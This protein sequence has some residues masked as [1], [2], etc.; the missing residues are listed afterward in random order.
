MASSAANEGHIYS[1]TYSN[2][3]FFSCFSSFSSPSPHCSFGLYGHF[4]TDWLPVCYR[5]RSTNTSWELR[6]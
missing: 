3:G 2:V 5:S 4:K 1:A 6:M